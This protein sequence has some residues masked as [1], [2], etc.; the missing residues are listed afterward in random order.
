MAFGGVTG[1]LSANPAAWLG[2]GRAYRTTASAILQALPI[3]RLRRSA[4]LAA[5]LAGYTIAAYVAFRYVFLDNVIFDPRA[6]DVGKVFTAAGEAFRSG[7]PVYSFDGEPFFYAP[8]I[9]LLFALLSLLPFPVCFGLV[10]AANFAGLRYLA[11]SWRAVGY[12]FWLLPV[13]IVPWAGTVDL[14][15]AA[16]IVLAI[17]RRSVVLPVLFGMMKFSPLLALD[18]GRWRRTLVVIGLAGVATLPVVWLWPEWLVQLA[19]GATQPFGLMVP[20]PFAA[21][22]PIGLLLVLSRRPAL[23]AL[24]AVIATPAFYLHTFALLLAPIALLRPGATVVE[25]TTVPVRWSS[26]SFGRRSPSP[27]RQGVV[28]SQGALALGG[29]SGAPGGSS[30]SIYRG[31]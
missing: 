21:R 3:V 1:R 9:V 8:P 7:R 5:S 22:L 31:C 20:I 24:G 12:A 27:G 29:S 6:S 13:A 30:Q 11:G 16:A 14:A 26:R 19:R 18:P 17:R 15:M 4:L 23:R 2:D 10:L 25:T 28:L